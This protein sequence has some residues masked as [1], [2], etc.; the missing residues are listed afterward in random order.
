MHNQLE[1]ASD[2]TN[3]MI[4]VNRVA[5][6]VI[7]VFNDILEK[8]HL[9]KNDI[10]LII[11]H[12]VVFEDHI[13]V[14]LR[15]EVDELLRTGTIENIGDTEGEV[16]VNFD[17]DAENI[18]KSEDFYEIEVVQRANKQHDKVFRVNVVSVVDPLEIYTDREGEVI[19]KKYSP[20]GELSAFAAQY[21]DTLYKTCNLSVIISDRDA[22]IASAGVSKKEYTEKKLSLFDKC[23]E[24]KF[25][26]I[27]SLDQADKETQEIILNW[28]QKRIG[29]KK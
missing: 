5:K 22:V 12:M 1:L 21:A 7:D 13:E 9:D 4:R 16:P 6:T 20:I 26:C 15:A 27:N 17:R 14:K 25:G 3:T 19:F 18:E 2:T 10:N 23:K 8:D 11:S 29:L 24:F 28:I